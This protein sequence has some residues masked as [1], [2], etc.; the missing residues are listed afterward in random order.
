M[1]TA[2]ITYT[3]GRTLPYLVVPPPLG[4]VAAGAGCMLARG[5]PHRGPKAAVPDRSGDQVVLRGWPVIF[6]GT[7]YAAA[8]GEPWGPAGRSACQ[9]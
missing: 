2:T 1:K 8:D 7:A 9:R 4:V 3:D 6:A 5:V